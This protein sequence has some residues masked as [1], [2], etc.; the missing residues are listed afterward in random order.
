MNEYFTKLTPRV[1]KACMNSKAYLR[2][3]EMVIN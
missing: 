2:A 1:M 3:T